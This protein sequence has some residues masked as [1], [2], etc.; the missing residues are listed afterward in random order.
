MKTILIIILTVFFTNNII[1]S[2]ELERSEIQEKYKWDLT[3]L[4]QSDESWIESKNKVLLEID[5]ISSFKG[6]FTESPL[7]MLNCLEFVDDIN[8]EIRRLSSYSWNKSNQDTRDSRYSAMK[9]ETN[10]LTTKFN[11]ATA[12]INPEILA[13]DESVI[14]NYI[15]QELRLKP[16]L[17]T[18]NRI[19]RSKKHTFSEGEERVIAEAG[20][21]IG[22]PVSIYNTFINTELNRNV[23]HYIGT[24][25]AIMNAKIN[26]DVFN[27][28]VRG[29]SNSLEMV[30]YP[31]SIPSSVYY[32]LISFAEKHL[33]IF[34][35]YLNIRKRLLKSDTMHF[36]DLSI[37]FFDDT[38]FKFSIEEAQELIMESMQFVGAENLSILEK[39]FNDRWIDMYPTP[40]KRSGSYA[41]F[42]AYKE[43]PYVLTNF[44]GQYEDVSTLTHELGH[45]LHTY[46][47]DRNQPFS[48]AFPSFFIAEVIPLTN[49]AILKNKMLEKITNDKQR[50]T[51]LLNNIE[52][53]VFNRIMVSEFELKI[54]EEVENGNTLTGDRISEIYLEI[55][56]KYYGHYKGICIIPDSLG[57]QWATDRLL[58]VRTYSIFRY[59]TSQIAAIDIA[60]SIYNNENNSVENYLKIL[61]SGG[62]D[63]PIN[64]LKKAGVDLTSTNPF[65]KS[66]NKISSE[67]DEIERLLVKL[68]KY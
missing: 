32:N 10:L 7:N 27:S 65:E 23:S 61:S 68:G 9:Q 31:D 28:R 19:I 6:N 42:G 54:H 36:S 59:A 11:T 22:A 40:G 64:I 44:S 45:V 57:M 51:F 39:A 50:L 43:H 26:A 63:Y 66:L 56:R 35:R 48:T 34:H 29:Y 67:M 30:L 8:E 20:M 46:M 37:P 1:F 49:E 15:L 4:Y 25:G 55:F 21:M 3:D 47:S 18:L 33:D 13:I 58:F 62:S 38:E 12:F 60:E 17:F 2:Q 5:K 24:L 16:Y 52:I 53:S 14:N 41:D